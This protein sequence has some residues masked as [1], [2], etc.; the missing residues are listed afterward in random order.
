MKHLLPIACIFLASCAARKSSSV[1]TGTTAKDS[2]ATAIE[3]LSARIDSASLVRLDV[4][5]TLIHP[6]ADSASFSAVLTGKP[7]RFSGSGFDLSMEIKDSVV[8]VKA[9]H[10][11]KPVA[12]RKVAYQREAQA[13]S[14]SDWMGASTVDL[15]EKQS[16]S[17]HETSSKAPPGNPITG[18]VIMALLFA[19]LFYFKK[20]A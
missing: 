7:I 16:K 2:T 15:S 10:Q 12:A 18:V 20:R 14:Q 13:K 4:V 19:G 11:P 1:T 17:H 6:E 5:D 3:S 9:R 8:T